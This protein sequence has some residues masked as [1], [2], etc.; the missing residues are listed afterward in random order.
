MKALEKDFDD[1]AVQNS[2]GPSI[3]SMWSD[4]ARALYGEPRDTAHD[5]AVW[6]DGMGIEPVLDVGCGNGVFQRSF[7]GRW[8]GLDRSVSQLKQ[9]EGPRV[10]GDA[11]VLPFPDGSFAGVVSLYTLYFFEEPAGVAREAMRVLVPGGWF[12][13]CAPS[14][15]DAPELDHVTPK[16]EAGSFAAEDIP[17]LL[18][19]HFREVAITVWDFPAFD[20]PDRETVAAYLYS[21]YFPQLGREE[22]AARARR[23]DVPVKL[24]KRGAWGVGRKPG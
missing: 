3:E 8:V 15:F 11:L 17:A 12:A 13:T 5:V 10:L 23:V 6:F 4:E 24:T 21:W 19:E 9:A 16:G 22:A 18:F 2:G 20:L 7:A 14:R 1:P